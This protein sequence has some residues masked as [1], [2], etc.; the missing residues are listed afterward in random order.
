MND[1][2]P[3]ERINFVR[4]LVK[5][6]RPDVADLVIYCHEHELTDIVANDRLAVYGTK[7]IFNVKKSKI[8]YTTQADS[9]RT[10]LSKRDWSE[11][12][13]NRHWNEL[14]SMCLITGIPDYVLDINWNR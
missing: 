5:N 10:G 14:C 9:R 11:V 8:I 13:M 1:L 3:D 4:K 12:E 7:R 2:S 6:Y